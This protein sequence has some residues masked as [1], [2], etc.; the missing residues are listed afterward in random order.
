MSKW[1]VTVTM[2]STIGEDDHEP[3]TTMW[4]RGTD[5]LGAIQSV[6]QNMATDDSPYTKVV[7]ITVEPAPEDQTPNAKAYV[8]A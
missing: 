1:N 6:I 3:V 7:S 4:A 8:G 5:D 2:I